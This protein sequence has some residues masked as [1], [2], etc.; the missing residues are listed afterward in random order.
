M[1]VVSGFTTD[2]F[3]YEKLRIRTVRQYGDHPLQTHI[4]TVFGNVQ[5]GTLQVS[6]ATSSKSELSSV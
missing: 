2:E 5:G 4:L 1:D 6:D 3:S